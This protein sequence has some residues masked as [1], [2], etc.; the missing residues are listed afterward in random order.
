MNSFQSKL[1][2]NKHVRVRQDH[3]DG[4]LVL[5][6]KCTRSWGDCMS[7]RECCTY[8]GSFDGGD[9]HACFKNPE[10]HAKLIAVIEQV[11]NRYLSGASSC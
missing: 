10:M 8:A 1:N 3:F 11:H 2:T 7:A 9:M 4:H 5:E 6:C